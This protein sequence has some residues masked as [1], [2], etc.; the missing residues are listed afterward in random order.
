MLTENG[1]LEV[2]VEAVDSTEEIVKSKEKK[3]KDKSEGKEVLTR[4]QRNEYRVFKGETLYLVGRYEELL[5]FLT[6]KKR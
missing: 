3:N 2:A 4:Q 5:K 6:E 1:D